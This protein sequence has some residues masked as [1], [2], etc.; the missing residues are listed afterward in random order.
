VHKDV[1]SLHHEAHLGTRLGDRGDGALDVLKPLDSDGLAPHAQPWGAGLELVPRR[2]TD[3]MRRMP[4]DG[5]GRSAWPR[6]FPPF[7]RRRERV[8]GHQPDARAV[9]ARLRP[10]RDSPRRQRIASMG[11]PA[12][13]RGG[14]LL[15]GTA[16]GCARCEDA[17]DRERDEVD[18]ELMAPSLVPRGPA[19]LAAQR[20]TLHIAQLTQTLVEG[21]NERSGRLPQRPA[22]DG[23]PRGLRAGAD[24]RDEPAPCDGDG[25]EKSDEAAC[26]GSPLRSRT[27]GAHSTRQVLGKELKFCR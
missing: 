13:E 11:H 26:P 3:G 21:F 17:F 1:G 16:R 7:P 14:G 4:E 5:H 10:A 9:A 23:L 15:S 27:C 24:R 19:L 12:R 18:R 25:D 6:L 8:R 20:L 22:A 2:G